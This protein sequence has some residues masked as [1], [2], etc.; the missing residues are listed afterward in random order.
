MALNEFIERD[1]YISPYSMFRGCQRILL[2]LH[3]LTHTR[4]LLAYPPRDIVTHVKYVVFL[5]NIALLIG[6]GQS[7]IISTFVQIELVF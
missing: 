7:E 5:T 4:A 6:S 3:F 1:K 2:F